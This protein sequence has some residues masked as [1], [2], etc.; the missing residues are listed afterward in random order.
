MSERKKLAYT[1]FDKVKKT[2]GRSSGFKEAVYKSGRGFTRNG[3]LVRVVPVQGLI[4][5]DYVHAASFH[6]DAI[7][8]VLQQWHSTLVSAYGQQFTITI[9]RTQPHPPGP[10]G[11]WPGLE[12]RLKSV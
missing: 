12:M 8:Q 11:K 7:K 3:F 6:P 4:I 5:V 9:V 10:I 2:L 1:Y